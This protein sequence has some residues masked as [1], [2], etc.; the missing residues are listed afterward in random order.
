[1]T[2]VRKIICLFRVFVFSDLT[3]KLDGKDVKCHRFVLAARSENWGVKDLAQ[4]SE[5]DLRGI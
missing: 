4:A 3:V 2:K 5:L 1:M